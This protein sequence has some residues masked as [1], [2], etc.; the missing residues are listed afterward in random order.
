MTYV[1]AHH[2]RLFGRSLRIEADTN[3]ASKRRTGDAFFYGSSIEQHW[4]FQRVLRFAK[5]A[6]SHADQSVALFGI[7]SHALLELQGN[8][9]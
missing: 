5:V 9:D 1:S 7:E 2:P 6:Q 3:K 8:A 4:L